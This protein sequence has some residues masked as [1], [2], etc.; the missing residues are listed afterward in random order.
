MFG[1]VDFSVKSH[2]ILQTD[3]CARL[4][5]TRINPRRIRRRI[6]NTTKTPSNSPSDRFIVAVFYSWFLNLPG[7]LLVTLMKHFSV[8]YGRDSPDEP[9]FA[10]AARIEERLSDFWN[11]RRLSGRCVNCA[12]RILAEIL[13]EFE[14]YIRRA[15]DFHKTVWFSSEN[16]IIIP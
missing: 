16:L 12:G 13:C 10:G 14:K 1:K 6:P 7:I 4:R 2:W 8:E 5:L 3:R 9:F 11:G 15:R